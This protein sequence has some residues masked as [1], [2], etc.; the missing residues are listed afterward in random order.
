MLLAAGAALAFQPAQRRLERLA[1]RWVFGKR[2][3]GYTV[4]TRFG[5]LLET[6]PGAADLLPRLADA[7]REGLA[8]EWVRVRLDLAPPGGLSALPSLS[9]PA[10]AHAPM[11]QR[12]SRIR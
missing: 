3:D 2:L 8:L 9:G 5:A 11:A 1:D 6:S 12:T 10:A 4:I 7:I